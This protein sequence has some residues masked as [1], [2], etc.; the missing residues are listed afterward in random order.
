MPIDNSDSQISG[1]N[2]ITAALLVIL[3]M[4]MISSNDAIVKLSSEDLGVG[5]MLFVRGSFA[6]LIFSAYIKFKGLPIVPRGGFTGWV[7][8]RAVCEC[9]ATVC[10]VFSLT[11]L[12]IAIA[13]TLV[14]TSP[15]L[16]TIA[17][18]VI[19]R[20]HVSVARWLAVLFGFIGVVMVTNPFDAEFSSAMLL[21]LAAAVFVCARDLFTQRIVST[22]HSAYVVLATLIVVT[23]AGLVISLFDWRPVSIS[24]TGWLLLCAI[25]LGNG[26]LCQV[27][28]IRK[29]ELSFIAPFSY[30]GILMATFYG[31]VIWQQWPSMLAF[32][33]MLLITGSGIYILSAGSVVAKK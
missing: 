11:L 27:M 4:V 7:S 1:K 21:P 23:V 9:C 17:A 12:P 28:A 26:F 20:E 13:S 16:V 2:N 22:L 29:A 18:A 6:V 33:G 15:I 30:V 24:R 19:L 31:F 32:A 3:G 14:W 10:F 8:M 25:L 5:Q